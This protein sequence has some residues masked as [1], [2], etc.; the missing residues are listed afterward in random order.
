[1]NTVADLNLTRFMGD[2]HVLADI[3]TPFDRNAV[4]PLESYKLAPGG[5]V[6]TTY[7]YREGTTDGA[8]RERNLKAFVSDESPAIWGMQ[9][10]WPVK[11]EY[12][13]VYLDAEYQTTII[14]RTKRD[15]VWVMART[16][17]ID[18]AYFAGLMQT[19]Q[20][21]GYDLAKIRIHEPMRSLQRQGDESRTKST[22]R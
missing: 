11:A 21:L 1:M 19:V 12:R 3:E 4:E 20:T 2:W 13:I 14:G 15:F 5:V 8:L 9:I 10:F 6:E 22:D 17:A 16:P 7:S 18:P